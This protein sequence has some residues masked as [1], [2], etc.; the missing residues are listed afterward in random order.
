VITVFLRSLAQHW[1]GKLIAVIVS[2]YDGDGGNGGTHTARPHMD[3][4]STEQQAES[5]VSETIKPTA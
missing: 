2:G 3:F 1:D 5:P 4:H